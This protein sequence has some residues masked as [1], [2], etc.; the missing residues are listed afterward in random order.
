MGEVALLAL[1][2][3]DLPIKT[4]QLWRGHLSNFTT[5]ILFCYSLCYVTLSKQ[6]YYPVSVVKPAI[7]LCMQLHPV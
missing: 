2:H 3:W 1:I 5:Q 4:V 6:L 7:S